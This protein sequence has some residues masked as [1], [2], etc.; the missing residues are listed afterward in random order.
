MLELEG[1]NVSCGGEAVLKDVSIS[2]AEGEKVA[3]VGPSGSGKTTLLRKLYELKGREASFIHQDYAL[4]PL[5]S[6]FHNI[7]M[8]RLDM[9][10]AWKNLV[11]L[12]R[13]DKAAVCEVRRILK[14]LGMDDKIFEKAGAL[15]GGE[16][17]RVAVARAL[18]RGAGVLLGDEPVSSIDPHHAG[19][20]LR[21]LTS[22]APTVILSLH[23]VELAIENFDRLIGMRRGSVLFDLP[24]GDVS[25]EV[26]NDLYRPC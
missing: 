19:E 22:S 9:Y 21:L 5:L 23:S 20:V 1:L 16:Q 15:S 3:L 13:P 7:Y 25:R 14:R 18:Y 6:A 17:Q 12:V 10:G 4:V 26:L 11:N 8:G 2:V 24:A